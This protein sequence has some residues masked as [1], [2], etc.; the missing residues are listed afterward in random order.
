[1]WQIG[2]KDA[3]DAHYYTVVIN[4]S[5]WMSNVR[6]FILS[7]TKSKSI[8]NVLTLTPQDVSAGCTNGNKWDL[9]ICSCFPIIYVYLCFIL[10]THKSTFTIN[11]GKK[12][13]KFKLISQ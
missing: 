11:G 7:K 10:C 8:I 4:R 5:L 12:I 13:I 2:Q 3:L 1:M 9:D 6:L